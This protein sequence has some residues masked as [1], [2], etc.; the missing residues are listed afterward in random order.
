METTYYKSELDD[1]VVKAVD[2]ENV[3]VKINGGEEKKSTYD[4][5]IVTNA[6]MGEQISPQEYEQA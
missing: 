3:F 4:S 6:M 2:D 5:E 1:A